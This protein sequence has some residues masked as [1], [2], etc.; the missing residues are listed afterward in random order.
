MAQLGRYPPLL[1][2]QVGGAVGPVAGSGDGKCPADDRPGRLQSPGDEEHPGQRA[3]GLE[4]DERVAG[5][6]AGREDG[7]GDRLVTRDVAGERRHVAQLVFAQQSTAHL[8]AGL[9]QDARL[10]HQSAALFDL[11]HSPSKKA[12][13][14]ELDRG[15]GGGVRRS[16]HHPLYRAHGPHPRFGSGVGA[17]IHHPLRLQW[18]GLE[19]LEPAAIAGGHQLEERVEQGERL[20]VMLAP[21]RLA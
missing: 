20:A 19:D 2:E 5:G 13:E 16:P 4:L 10:A 1:G 21:F 3:K 8:A 6:H 15:S 17:V 7:A 14:V 12:A 9:Q 11:A 18:H